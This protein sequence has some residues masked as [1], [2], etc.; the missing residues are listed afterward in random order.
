MI[1]ATV[2]DFILRDSTVADTAELIDL[3]KLRRNSLS[4]RTAASIALGDNVTFTSSRTGQRVSGTVEKV[5]IKNVIVRTALGR[6][7][8]PANML[9]VA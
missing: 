8:V 6:Y 7:R 4:K 3:I 5:A 1:P 9:E 2:R